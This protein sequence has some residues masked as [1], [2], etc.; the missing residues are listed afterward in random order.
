MFQT[1]IYYK[2]DCV[3]WTKYLWTV[4]NK[5]MCPSTGINTESKDAHIKN[6]P[7]PFNPDT[8]FEFK[9]TNPSLVKLLVYNTL[10]QVVAVLV[11]DKLKKGTH[12]IK[13]DAG[14]LSS[15]IYF[16]KFLTDN[17]VITKRI[18]LIK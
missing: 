11:N 7:N 15:G 10:G 5:A 18:T 6:Y 13:W 12:T 8:N 4:L 2:Q 1:L 3:P 14:N 9:L 16:Y 17:N